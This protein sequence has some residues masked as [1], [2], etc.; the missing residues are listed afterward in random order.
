M[1]AA[2]PRRERLLVGGALLTIALV[3]WL[4]LLR[5]ARQTNGDCCTVAAAG[6]G[7]F[8]G[9]V[10]ALFVMWSVMMIAMMLPSALPMVLTF[11]AVSRKRR[12]AGRDYVPV[13]IFVAG[14]AIVWCAF[15]VLAAVAQWWLHRA[16]LL[17]PAMASTSAWFGSALLIGAGIFQFTPLK[18]TCLA[19]CRSTFEFIMTR[20]RGGGVG[21]LRMGIEHGAYCTGCCWALMT[22]LFV[23]GVMNLA[24]IA[25]LTALV[26]IEKILPARAQ[27]SFASGVLL[28]AWAAAVLTR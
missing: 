19:N 28:L 20:W 25:A 24:W 11:A 7:T 9:A 26:C 10:P 27:V 2:L 4:Y 22:L 15:S 13:A 8:F 21:A 1:S 14:Y 18:R 23:L 5:D 12:A 16:A 17:S 6:G 3:A